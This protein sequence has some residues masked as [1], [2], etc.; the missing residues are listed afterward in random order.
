MVSYFPLCSCLLHCKVLYNTHCNFSKQVFPHLFRSLWTGNSPL[1]V[2]LQTTFFLSLDANWLTWVLCLP[3]TVEVLEYPSLQ[4]LQTL[5]AHTAGCYCIAI[6]P[7]GR[8]WLTVLHNFQQ[9]DIS[10]SLSRSAIKSVTFCGADEKLPANMRT[11]YLFWWHRYLAVGSADALVSLWDVAEMLCVRTF[12]K[13][14]WV[15]NALL[16]SS[17]SIIH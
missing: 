4:T 8:C 9:S 10:L 7:T 6:D 3:G 16:L 12:T 5:V 13:L 2:Q 15:L 1:S 11:L 14:E 17:I